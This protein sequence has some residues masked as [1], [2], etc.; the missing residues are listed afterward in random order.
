MVVA[1]LALLVEQHLEMVVMEFK[2]LLADLLFTML[3]VVAE[4]VMALHLQLEV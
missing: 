4:A 1:V 2:A 3:V